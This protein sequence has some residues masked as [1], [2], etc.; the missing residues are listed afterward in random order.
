MTF[1]LAHPPF[2]VRDAAADDF[3]QKFVFG[4]PS[5]VRRARGRLRRL[6]GLNRSPEQP[7]N[8]A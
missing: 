4:V 7:R 3:T 1:P 5:L 2:M 8:P 6:F